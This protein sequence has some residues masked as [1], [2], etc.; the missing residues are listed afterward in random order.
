MVYNA[1]K[2]FAFARVSDGIGFVEL[3]FCENWPAMKSAGLVRGSYQ[4]F[5]PNQ[6]AKAQ[7][8]F[9]YSE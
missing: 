1:G 8:C 4:F 3:K 5:R 7:V 6:S 9:T 2:R